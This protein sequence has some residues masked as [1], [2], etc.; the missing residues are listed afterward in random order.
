MS[1]KVSVTCDDDEVQRDLSRIGRGPT[2]S[3][4]LRFDQILTSQFQ[5]TQFVV[6]V[7]TG[8][9]RASGIHESHS[10][11]GHGWEGKIA[12]G[13]PLLYSAADPGPPRN[14]GRYAIYEFTKATDETYD[15]NWIRAADLDRR[16]GAYAEAITSW[17]RD[18]L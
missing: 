12:Y 6:H 8:S 16:S 15:H 1:V 10:P 7:I 14:P 9:L 5:R 3:A 11:K 13:G 18:E 2:P 17:M 4:H